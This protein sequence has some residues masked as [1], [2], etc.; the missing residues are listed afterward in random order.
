M[1]DRR[2]RR[3]RMKWVGYVARMGKRRGAY[4]A[5]VR[6]REGRRLFERR[7]CRLEDN[8]KID[9][10]EVVLGAWTGSIWFRIETGVGLL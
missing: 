3:R 9:F 10:R 1:P 4:C 5:L 7:R 2:K 6:K 8:I